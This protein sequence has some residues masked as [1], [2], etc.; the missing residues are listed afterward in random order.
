M[1]NILKESL[2]YK[3]LFNFL[4]FFSKGYKNSFFRKI[5]ES[6]KKSFKSS[7]TFKV[8][9]GYIDKKPLFTTSLTYRGIRFIGKYTGKFADKINKMAVDFYNSIYSVS[10]S[11]K[12]IDNFKEE[13]KSEMSLFIGL[14]FMVVS[15]SYLSFSILFGRNY[16]T[17]IHIA[18]AIFFVGMLIFFAGRNKEI[19]K[20]SFTYKLV[21]YIVELV[22]M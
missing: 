17:R 13:N 15:I 22:K 16:E 10:F 1:L 8:V 5:I 19:V 9:K 4:S 2:F 12:F 6:F 11:K 3:Y 18:W 14:L 21:K 7:F 20:Q